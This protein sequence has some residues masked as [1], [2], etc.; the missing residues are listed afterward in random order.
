MLTNQEV[1]NKEDLQFLQSLGKELKE[2]NTYATRKPVVFRLFKRKIQLHMD[3]QS[4]DECVLLGN[5]KYTAE[6]IAF[7]D[8]EGVKGMVETLKTILEMEY[9]FKAEEIADCHTLKDIEDLC[10]ENNLYFCLTGY[11]EIDEYENYFLTQ[12]GVNDYIEKNNHKL[13]PMTTFYV[14]HAQSPELERLL[15]IVEKFADTQ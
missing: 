5:T 3:P 11:K 6:M 8:H 2:Q 10:I 14:A 4:Y 7:E 12:R 1:L 9:H 13:D 15:E